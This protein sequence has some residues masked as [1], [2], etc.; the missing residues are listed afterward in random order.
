MT[1]FKDGDRVRVIGD[2]DWSGGMQVSFVG[3][4]VTVAV[5]VPGEYRLATEGDF[6]ST[7][8]AA[9]KVEPEPEAGELKVGQRVKVEP[10]SA[11][12]TYQQHSG[13]LGVITG[14]RGTTFPIQVRMDL[15]GQILALRPSEVGLV[16]QAYI[17]PTG[18][19]PV[20]ESSWQPLGYLS[21]DG[22][23]VSDE[24]VNDGPV[25]KT[26]ALVTDLTGGQLVTLYNSG[27][28]SREE[29]RSFL[30]L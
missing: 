7:E 14:I 29:A 3:E 23:T 17:A 25:T 4:L 13:G 26:K 30:G 10:Y 11:S 15:D 19:S 16:G 27:I 22:L 28:L 8:P 24:L 5:R 1:E 2:G 21:T 9:E 20:E 6:S 12:L 18:G